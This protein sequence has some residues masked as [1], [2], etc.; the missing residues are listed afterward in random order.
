V[1]NRG[2]SY[3]LFQQHTEI[4]RWVLLGISIAAAV[5]LSLWMART[6]SRFLAV[7]LGLIVGGAVG[8]AID[9]LAYGAV[10]DFVHF[11]IGQF[12]WYV[13]NIADAAIVAGVI[14][15]IYDSLVLDKRRAHQASA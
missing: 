8:N 15:L 5:G 6:P 11:H 10:F 7:S 14:G 3:G 2:I 9:R 12:S 13:F 1:W 4:G